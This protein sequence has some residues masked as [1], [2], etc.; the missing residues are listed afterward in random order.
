MPTAKVTKPDLSTPNLSRGHQLRRRVTEAHAFYSSAIGAIENLPTDYVFRA[1]Q[2]YKMAAKA[3][4]L[5]ARQSG[6]G[7][8][9]FAR[10]FV[11][12]TVAFHKQAVLMAE[13]EALDT[14]L[15]LQANHAHFDIIKPLTIDLLKSMG[16]YNLQ[17]DSGPLLWRFVEELQLP[18]LPAVPMSADNAEAIR[19]SAPVK[20]PSVV[21]PKIPGRKILSLP[22]KP[23]L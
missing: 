6:D 5:G 10:D 17:T 23:R 9:G 13:T 2:W 22:G 16:A 7:R 1:R 21:V 15:P 19:A 20:L 4:G 11:A 8:V 14:G 18:S 12:V 3:S